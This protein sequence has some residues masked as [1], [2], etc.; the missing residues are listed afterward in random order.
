MRTVRIQ[1]ACSGVVLYQNRRDSSILGHRGCSSD[2]SF[3]LLFIL[4]VYIV[5][6]SQFSTNVV[7]S[8]PDLYITKTSYNP[9]AIW[10]YKILSDF[11]PRQIVKR[12]GLA[13][14]KFTE[15]HQH[16]NYR[17]YTIWYLITFI[18]SFSCLK[19]PDCSLNLV[20]KPVFITKSTFCHNKVTWGLISRNHPCFQ[21]LLLCAECNND[22]WSANICLSICQRQGINNC[23]VDTSSF[24][25]VMCHKLNKFHIGAC[26]SYKHGT[27]I[28][29]WELS[30]T[31]IGKLN[32]RKFCFH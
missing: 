3:L 32:R 4:G 6:D 21:H 17:K 7:N 5:I 27:S 8:S 19:T 16:K 26:D 23:Q 18:R 9:C 20:F 28:S 15:L 22:E 1:P 13:R 10:Y 12:F 2:S 14:K 29:L 30:G 24:C 25:T 31:A 11:R